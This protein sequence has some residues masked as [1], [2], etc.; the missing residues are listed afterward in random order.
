MQ[1]QSLPQQG[2]TQPQPIEFPYLSADGWAQLVSRLETQHPDELARLHRGLGILRG[3]I[4]QPILE[5]ATSYLV[6]SSVPG[7]YYR[8]NTARCTCP[9]F[10]GRQVRCKHIWALTVLV[11]GT[12]SARFEALA[13]ATQ[14][15]AY[16]LTDKALVALDGPEPVPAA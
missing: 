2:T 8:A 15:I 5:D 6:P 1:S 12:I 11:A 3:F 9:D 10:L 13:R 4:R 16:E 7:Q 14:P